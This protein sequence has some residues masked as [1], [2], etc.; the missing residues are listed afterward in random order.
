M[1][2]PAAC[3]GGEESLVKMPRGPNMQLDIAF[4]KTALARSYL[5]QPPVP[6]SRGRRSLLIMMN[7]RKTVQD[8]LPAMKSLGLKVDDVQALVAQGLLEPAPARSSRSNR[9]SRQMIDMLVEGA[10]LAERSFPDADFQDTEPGGPAPAPVTDAELPATA[11]NSVAEEAAPNSPIDHW[12]RVARFFAL[13][14]LTHMLER[15]GS[16]WHDRLQAV[17]TAPALM[18]WIDDC[19]LYLAAVA[20]AERADRFR[21]QVVAFVPPGLR[22]PATPADMG[23]R[24]RALL[25]G[26]PEPSQESQHATGPGALAEEG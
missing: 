26:A 9:S 11:T 12:L 2:R 17:D 1:R 13:D 14:L 8:L 20:G 4:A 15:P 5:S 21:M 3:G 25:R 16:D 23:L 19:A 24:R 7:G 18:E 6:G 10:V 22:G